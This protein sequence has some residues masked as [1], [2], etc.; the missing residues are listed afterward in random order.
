[1]F[2]VEQCNAVAEFVGNYLDFFREYAKE[3]EDVPVSFLISLLEGGKEMC[4]RQAAKLVEEMAREDDE[5]ERV[6]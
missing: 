4:E 6:Y 1:M 3:C 5:D 2:S